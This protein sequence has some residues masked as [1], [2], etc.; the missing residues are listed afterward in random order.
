[1]E[2]SKEKVMAGPRP[3]PTEPKQT[4]KTKMEGLLNE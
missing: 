3:Q 4:T 1:M 2:S